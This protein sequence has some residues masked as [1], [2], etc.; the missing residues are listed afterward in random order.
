MINL[1]SDTL[2]DS[3]E[4]RA[5]VTTYGVLLSAIRPEALSYMTG[6]VT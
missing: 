2:S 4:L 5:P 6:P 1:P 3:G